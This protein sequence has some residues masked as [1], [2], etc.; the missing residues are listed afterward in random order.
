MISCVLTILEMVRRELRC[1]QRQEL[2]RSLQSPHPCASE[3]VELGFEQWAASL[4]EE[5]SSDLVD[6]GAGRSVRWVLGRG[7]LEAK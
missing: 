7:W 3:I 2:N 4:P 1:R 5:K 6:I